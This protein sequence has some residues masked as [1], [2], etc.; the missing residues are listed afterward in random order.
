MLIAN[1]EQKLLG[2]FRARID[3]RESM[4]FRTLSG[5]KPQLFSLCA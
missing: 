1:S 3:G 2:D 4:E 5:W